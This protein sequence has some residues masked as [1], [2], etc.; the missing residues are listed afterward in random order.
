MKYLLSTGRTT[1]KIEKYI[2]DLFKLNI[3]I[4][5]EDI[6]NSSIGFDFI[7]TNVKKDELRSEVTFR[8]RTLVESIKKQ[9]DRGIEINIESIDIINESRVSVV[10]SVNQTSEEIKFNLFDNI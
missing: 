10:V 7:M 2:L 9:F 4:Y 3:S 6:P 8:I 1:D 5:P